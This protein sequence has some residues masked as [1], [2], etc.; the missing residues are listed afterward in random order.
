MY[1]KITVENWEDFKSSISKLE[2]FIFRG[3]ID[4]Y[5]WELQPTLEREVEKQEI[6]PLDL[7]GM[8]LSILKEFQQNAHLFLKD[9]PNICERLEW[10][11]LLQ[12]HGAPTRLLDF[13]LSPYIATFFAINNSSINGAVWAINKETLLKNTI[14]KNDNDKKIFE[15]LENNKNYCIDD[16]LDEY[17]RRLAEQFL[18]YDVDFSIKRGLGEILKNPNLVIGMDTQ[19]SHE[20]KVIQKGIFL[21]STNLEDKFHEV[22]LDHLGIQNNEPQI[23]TFS[24]LFVKLTIIA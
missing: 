13:T 22:L 21:L 4:D 18:H 2:N 8:E 1:C 17:A 9:C 23:V 3:Q 14:E 10:F 20:R 19:F 24:N 7:Y 6:K 12:H 16:T 15:E 5:N 11:S